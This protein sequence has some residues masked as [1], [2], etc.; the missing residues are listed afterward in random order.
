MNQQVIQEQ[1]DAYE[2]EGLGTKTKDFASG[3]KGKAIQGIAGIKTKGKGF[4]ISG[5]GTGGLGERGRMSMEFST[6]DVNVTGEIDKSAILRVIKRNQPK[7][8]RCYQTSLNEKNSVQG[9]LSMKWIISA[10]GRGRNA[11]S[12]RSDIDSRTLKS[13]V[14]NVLES[15]I[16]PEPP[17]GQI[18]EVQFTFRFYL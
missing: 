13:C 10:K 15:L 2:G 9:N 5:T 17:S 12:V 7:F 8:E 3:G 1:P 14:A 4:G 6:S 18:P 11:R 16:F